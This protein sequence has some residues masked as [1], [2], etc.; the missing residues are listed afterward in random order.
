M[1]S[2]TRRLV[3]AALSARSFST[4]LSWRTAASPKQ[5]SP[6]L[7]EGEQVIHEKLTAKFQPSHLQVQDVS[8]EP[9]CDLWSEYCFSDI[10]CVPL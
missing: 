2:L 7:S 5:S 6:S 1:L 4:T 3:P 9:I 10:T 8:G